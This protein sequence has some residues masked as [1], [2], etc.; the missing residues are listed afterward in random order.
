MDEIAQRSH[1]TDDGLR[2]GR[3]QIND[4]LKQEIVKKALEKNGLD[5]KHISETFHANRKIVTSALIIAL[6]KY[7]V[8]ETLKA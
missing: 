6:I 5:S 7:Y 4:L 8:N 1:D 3:I 2:T